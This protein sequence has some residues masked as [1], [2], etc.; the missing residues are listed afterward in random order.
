MA[1]FVVLLVVI[2]PTLLAAAVLGVTR[3][4]ERR[5]REPRWWPEFERQFRDY[6]QAWR[7]S[8]SPQGPK[9]PQAS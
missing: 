7:A 3:L 9:P 5:R 1:V 4:R 6:A 2:A 8:S